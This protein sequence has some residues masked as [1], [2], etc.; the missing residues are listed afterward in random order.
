[1]ELGGA[2]W[3]W[4]ELDGAELIYMG[5]GGARCGWVEL[6]GDGCSWMSQS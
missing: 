5:L 2:G 6:D 4:V 3:G 1:M